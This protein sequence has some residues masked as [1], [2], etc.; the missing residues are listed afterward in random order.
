MAELSPS[1]EL[2]LASLLDF[3]ERREHEIVT[4]VAGIRGHCYPVPV[5]IK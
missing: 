5:L 2:L 1:G 3:A 4:G